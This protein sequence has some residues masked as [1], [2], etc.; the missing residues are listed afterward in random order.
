[1]SLMEIRAKCRRLKQ[2]ENLK[3]V[4]IDYLQLM[5]S[6]K[7]VES[8]QQEVSEFSRALK[9]L[10]KE[11]EVPVIA[12]SQLNRGAEQ[13]TDKKPAMSDLRESG[14][15]TADTRV[16]LADSGAQMS[17]AA[18]VD[19]YRRSPGR[20]VLVWSLDESLRYVR[21][22]MT[23][24]FSTG[25]R[26]VFRLTLASGK[27]VRATE[28]HPFLTTSGWSQL[29]DLRGGSRIAVPRHLPAPESFREELDDADL[30]LGALILSSRTPDR[31]PGRLAARGCSIGFDLVEMSERQL[32]PDIASFPKRQIGLLIDSLFALDGEVTVDEETREGR[33]VLRH[34]SR[35]LLDDVAHLLLRFGVSTSV[36]AADGRWELDV[37]GVDDQRR[38]LQE[39]AVHTERSTAADLL[40]QIVRERS[41]AA[42]PGGAPVPSRSS[43]RVTVR[44]EDFPDGV[45]GDDGLSLERLDELFNSLDLDLEASNDV[46]W[47]T[48]VGIEPDGVEEVFDATVLG[49]H[50][51]VANGIAVHN[52]IEQDADIVILLHREAAYEKDSP[53]EGE[54]DLIVA[55]HRNGPTD[56]IVVAFQ[57]H[58]SRFTNMATNF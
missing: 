21:R 24:V 2:R 41:D 56:T 50:N 5:S 35:R 40:L 18:L 48:V 29:G 53:R 9:L 11:L 15:L 25:V 27:T 13:R 43:R 38:F 23:S 45:V 14:C 55:K 46:L 17:I 33:I 44:P 32:M 22:P 10:A 4:V 36:A 34:P 1:M 49:T 20:E 7:R 12:I 47:D 8:R 28:N 52:S 39:I 3:L 51:F 16:T 42:V 6:G 54:A 30:R 31:P 58:F 57:G 26:P 19:E 37:R